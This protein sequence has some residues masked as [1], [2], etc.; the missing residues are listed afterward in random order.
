MDAVTEIKA[1]LDIVDLVGQ[2]VQ[3]KKAGRNFK[4][5]CPFHNEKTPSFIV[6]AERQFAWCFGCQTG[7]DIFKMVELLEG[8]DFK[9]ALKILAEKAGVELPQDFAAGPKK[10]K[11]DKLIEINSAAAEF[12]VQELQKN[13]AAQKYLETRNLKPETQK[14]WEIGY[15]PDSYEALFPE[16]LKKGY[17]K[18]DLIEAGVAGLREM[19]NQNLY[20][21]FRGRIIFPIQD[22]QGR[23]V[24]FTGRILGDGE[25]K[26]LNSSESPVFQK[27]AIL[28]GY[29]RAKEA[30]R[31][32]KLA[33]VME[34]QMDVIA[35]H[36]AGFKN[37]VASS[38]TAL[39]EYHLTAL[40]KIVD[41][42]LFA[43]DMDAAGLESTRRALT[44]AATA[45]LPA[46]VIVLPEKY[47]DP[48]EAIQADPQI[49]AQALKNARAP[50]EFFFE[51]IYRDKNLSEIKIKKQ[52][53]REL[54]TY[55]SQLV[56]AV[57]REEFIRR[58][59]SKLGIS[60]EAL[61]DE[62][63]L[64][65]TQVRSVEGP[66][67]ENTAEPKLSLEQRLLGLLLIYPQLA[68]Y[69]VGQLTLPN[70]S[71]GPYAKI[72]AALLETGATEKDLPEDLQKLS[73]YISDQYSN[74]SEEK[75]KQEIGAILQKLS[76]SSR[77]EKMHQLKEAM[78]TAEQAGDEAKAAELFEEYRKL[79]GKA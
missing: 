73:L 79:L 10:E 13:A 44:L 30:L 62:A 19:G 64:V 66:S 33:I 72:W 11:K 75:I 7:G 52:I 58:L 34:G 69:F 14:E 40:K 60:E 1:R 4:G 39:T 28:F 22:H 43:F 65:R 2:Y 77:E 17:E 23:V 50:V 57:E 78:E 76:R 46:R 61:R 68:K 26:Y 38:G 5:C 20:D 32:Q 70:L 74:L 36:Q 15:A 71:A 31:A 59:S 54:L 18:K 6:S 35:C 37:V 42:V 56:S 51:K 25:P 48:D 3:L 41:E 24:A 47:K 29:T 9:E 8:V 27:G 49:F 63:A 55:A 21:K 67:A 53:A 45:D 12:F 16:L